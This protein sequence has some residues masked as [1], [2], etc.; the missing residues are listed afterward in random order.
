MEVTRGSVQ[1]ILAGETAFQPVVHISN[2]KEMPSNAP[3]APPRWKCLFGDYVQSGVTGMLSTQLSHL[4][5]SG[6][7]CDGSLF[8]MTDFM[9]NEVSGAKYVLPLS[10]SCPVRVHVPHT[11]FLIL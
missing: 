3:N 6:E 2:V 11:I 5:S 10:C 7:L 4:A 8:Q 1:R 9:I